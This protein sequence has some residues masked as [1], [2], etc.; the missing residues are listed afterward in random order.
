[1]PDVHHVIL[2][3]M[4]LSILLRIG[5]DVTSR[6]MRLLRR[7]S[8][9][10]IHKMSR[11]QLGNSLLEAH[12]SML[13]GPC[14]GG[15][16]LFLEGPAGSGKTTL[17]CA[18]IRHLLRRRISPAAML[19]LV[20]QQTLGL[21]Y[22]EA[23]RG[24]DLPAGI[25]VEVVTVGGLIRR[26]VELFWPV[27]AR[28]A[29]FA[30]HVRPPVFLTLETT[31]Y[32]MQRVTGL[33]LDTR[34]FEGITISRGRLVSQLI[35]NLNKA[36]L[37][38]FPSE[39]ISDRLKSAWAG[40]SSR[41]RVYDQAGQRALDFRRYCLQHNLLDFS[42]QLE[43]FTQYLA[44][45]R[46]FRDYLFGRYRHLFVDNVEE[47]PPVIHDLLEDWVASCESAWIIYDRDGGYRAF[48]GA[49]PEN[50][51]RLR[52]VCRDSCSLTTSHV[53]SA[54]VE[55][56]RAHLAHALQGGA[57]SAV[58]DAGKAF[59]MLS[60]S[61]RA[62]SVPRFQPQMLTLVAQE[63]S[64]LVDG[65]GVSPAEIVVLAPFLSDTLRFTLANDLT[66]YGLQV[67]S[68]RPS[69]ALSEEPATRCLLTLAA[70]AHP[71]WQLVP[72]KDDVSG[73]LLQ[74]LDG[75]DLVRA[76]LLA[77]IVYRIRDREP[78]LSS[79]EQIAP[80]VQ[81]RL[82]YSLGERYEA[83]RQWLE[84][85]RERGA[86]FDLDHFFSLLFDEVL[87]RKGFGFHRNLD[88]AGQ[89]ANLIESVRRFRQV[90]AE[91]ELPHG[92]TIGREYVEMVQQGVLAAQY[93]W[94]WRIQPQNAILLAPA[95][96]FL[97]YNRPVDYQFWLNVG[98]AGWW[99]RIFQPLTHPFVL[100][101]QWP[102]GRVWEDADEYQARQLALYRLVIG[103]LRRCRK[104]VYLGISRLNEQGYE[105][106]GPLLQAFN[107]VKRQLLADRGKEHA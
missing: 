1:M 75:L 71:Y 85:Y 83:L 53:M 44:S 63:I 55:A 52:D 41:F 40:E 76:N 68:H 62:D 80:D 56:L 72:G 14:E 21:P 103:L 65:Q 24:N 58:G 37:A 34:G 28:P 106:T 67:R 77:Q 48:L 12:E 74:S 5:C 45:L 89:A 73:A 4:L 78:Y 19:V 8:S 18:R 82:T 47:N 17:C 61:E 11:V 38:G 2:P 57:L 49:D 95:Y 59:S 93:E 96:T 25:P 32:Y 30:D 91:S 86:W 7:H 3:A 84:T 15:A 46:A 99:E 29:G 51:Y 87:S 22:E 26:H 43:V 27:I 98:S 66:Q 33:E 69:R 16:T 90:V 60:S 97:M 81:V 88:A 50:A 100:N 42:L 79:F 10:R 13:T 6:S 92:R 39:D 94:G 107:R 102:V 23:L 101:R 20:P 36:A 9:S 31:Q 64:G 35:D 70:L 104:R 54:D 105:E